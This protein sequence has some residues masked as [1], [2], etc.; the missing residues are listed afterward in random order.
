[1]SWFFFDQLALNHIIHSK[2]YLYGKLVIFGFW[3]IALIWIF[4]TLTAYNFIE[5][6]Y[7]WSLNTN[8]SKHG[9]LK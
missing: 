7:K 8:Y 9:N 1:M 3:Q 5:K 4:A 2:K 6:S